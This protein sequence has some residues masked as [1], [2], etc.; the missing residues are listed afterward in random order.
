LG[1]PWPNSHELFW[2]YSQGETPS[3]F[4]EQALAPLKGVGRVPVLITGLDPAIHSQ[5]INEIVDTTP[6]LFRGESIL[7]RIV[8]KSDESVRQGAKLINNLLEGAQR[9]REMPLWWPLF[10][11]D[12]NSLQPGELS[13]A[14]GDAWQYVNIAVNPFT[15]T[16]VFDDLLDQITVAQFVIGLKE[17]IHC[18]GQIALPSEM[19]IFGASENPSYDLF[20]YADQLHV[21]PVVPTCIFLGPASASWTL[22]QNCERLNSYLQVFKS[23]TE[24]LWRSICKADRDMV[25]GL[26]A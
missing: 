5:I 10:Q 2:G 12:F 23:A 7:V 11:P 21:L 17:G 18:D 1:A 16:V 14:F 13:R 25:W 6:P 4:L 24:I 3:V 15:P 19:K 8:L 9:K 20:S 22:S 26:S